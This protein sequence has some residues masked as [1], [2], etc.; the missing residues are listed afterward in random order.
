MGVFL[1][2]WRGRYLKNADRDMKNDSTTIE[3]IAGEV[4]ALVL[5]AGG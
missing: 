4:T 5:Q 2:L 1:T 3:S